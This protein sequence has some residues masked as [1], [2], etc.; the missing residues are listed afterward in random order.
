MLTLTERLKENNQINPQS[1]I[2][3]SIAMSRGYL[4]TVLRLYYLRHGFQYFDPMILIYMVA[5]G[6]TA[7]EGIKTSP[8]SSQ[9][10][11]FRS[12]LILC[13]KG[14]HDQGT[15]F[16][17]GK[18]MFRLI[19]NQMDPEDVSLLNQCAKLE[20]LD[21]SESLK[22]EYIESEWPNPFMDVTQ[23]SNTWDSVEYIQKG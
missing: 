5:L 20:E 12:T 3:T 21:E 4:E 9:Q 17:F 18:F 14:I 16:H 22:T 1:S 8:L 7:I 6:W 15:N 10:N 13:A 19:C 11:R 2:N 23:E